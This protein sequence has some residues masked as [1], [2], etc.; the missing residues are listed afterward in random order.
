MKFVNMPFRR[1]CGTCLHVAVSHE[2]LET[3]KR[4]LS[5]KEIDVNKGNSNGDMPLRIACVG[6][7]LE[8]LRVKSFSLRV[9]TLGCHLHVQ[10]K[11]ARNN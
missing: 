7:N 11:S 9:G 2:H 6:G 3:V 10:Q 4:L 8:I 1:K 5:V